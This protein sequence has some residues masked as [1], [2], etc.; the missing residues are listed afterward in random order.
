MHLPALTLA[1]AFG[2]SSAAADPHSRRRLAAAP[3]KEKPLPVWRWQR[4][5]MPGC[6]SAGFDARRC[7]RFPPCCRCGFARMK[8]PLPARGRQR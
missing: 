5:E 3:A 7:H 2:S 4:L 1:S 8:K 6:F